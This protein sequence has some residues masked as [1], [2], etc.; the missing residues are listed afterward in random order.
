M[1]TNSADALRAELTSF[2]NNSDSL[3]KFWAEVRATLVG[4][5]DEADDDEELPTTVPVIDRTDSLSPPA[6]EGAKFGTGS[7]YLEKEQA[8]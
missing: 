4:I 2:C 6:V 5:N 7:K 3:A 8:I 1:T